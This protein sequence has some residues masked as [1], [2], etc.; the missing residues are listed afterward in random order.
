MDGDAV[1]LSHLHRAWLH[2]ARAETCHLKH[3]V[4]RNLLHAAR[5]LDNARVGGVDSVNVRVD[6]AGIRADCARDCHG[7]GIR[8]TASKCHGV[9]VGICALKASD[10]DNVALFKLLVHTFWLDS[11]NTPLGMRMIC[12]HSCHAAGEGYGGLSQGAERHREQCNRDLLTRRHE[13]IHFACVLI[14]AF[15]YLA[16]QRDEI[17]RRIAHGRY[18][19]D[20]AI[21]GGFL[22]Q[23]A[24]CYV[25]DLLRGSHR[26]SAKLLYN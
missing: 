22:T 19:H 15:H 10:N 21:I 9:A 23:Y 1:E 12:A 26:T 24:L 16:S 20:N 8:P 14:G 6:L 5:A 18:H 13:H 7:R 17:I 3:L 4:V 2:N 11:E 25:L